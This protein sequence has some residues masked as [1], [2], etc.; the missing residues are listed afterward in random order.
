[1]H[2]NNYKSLVTKKLGILATSRFADRFKL[3]HANLLAHLPFS[4]YFVYNNVLS[5]SADEINTISQIS[6]ISIVR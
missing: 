2:H 3:G 6:K 5:F 4:L 1:M